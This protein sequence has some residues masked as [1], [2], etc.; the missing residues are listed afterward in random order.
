MTAIF[1]STERDNPRRISRETL[2]DARWEGW[3]GTEL[4]AMTLHNGGKIGF[5]KKTVVKRFTTSIKDGKACSWSQRE[6][7]RERSPSSR[8]SADAARQ[9]HKRGRTPYEGQTRGGQESVDRDRPSTK[10]RRTL[11]EDRFPSLGRPS[12]L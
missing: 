6:R 4:Y 3:K 7:E 9:F 11:P 1:P 5:H 2:D 8:L 12:S 10:D